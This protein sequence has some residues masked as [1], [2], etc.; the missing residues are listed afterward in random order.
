MRVTV[1]RTVVSKPHGV[2][3]AFTSIL[4]TD[5]QLTCVVEKSLDRQLFFENGV[6]HVSLLRSAKMKRSNNRRSALLKPETCR[7]HARNQG[8]ARQHKKCALPAISHGYPG[9]AIS[10]Q[11]PSQI[12]DTINDAGK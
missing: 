11:H 4:P 6:H 7:S 3:T 1:L 5:G 8:Y 12:S 9:D 2:K 10:G